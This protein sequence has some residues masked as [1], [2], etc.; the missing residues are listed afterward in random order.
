MNPASHCKHRVAVIFML[1]DEPLLNEDLHRRLVG[2]MATLQNEI[3]Y[4][5]IAIIVGR[6]R[7]TG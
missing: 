4:V 5:H 3:S 2:A 1:L 6:H 7:P